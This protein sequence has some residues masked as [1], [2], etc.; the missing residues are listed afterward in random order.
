MPGEPYNGVFFAA[1]CPPDL[2]DFDHDGKLDAVF[3]SK[4]NAYILKGRGDGSFDPTPTI[5]PIPGGGGDT[6]AVAAADFD[7]DGNPDFAVLYRLGS[8]YTNGTVVFVYYGNGDSTFS[9]PLTYTIPFHAYSLITAS[10]LNRDGLA[11]LVLRGINV[12]YDNWS[13]SILHAKPG[14]A[15][16]SEVNYIAGIG[17]ND[18]ASLDVNQDGFPDLLIANN[19]ANSVTVL[20]NPGNVP[21]VSGILTASPEPSLIN[22]PFTLTATL[23]PPPPPS[24]STLSGTVSFF[25]MASPSAHLLLPPTLPPSRSIT[26]SAEESIRSWQPGP[27]TPTI[28]PSP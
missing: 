20:I 5:L 9:A 23:Y 6:A 7:G 11:D 4:S 17:L 1:N 12:P 21:T 19:L 14:R 26:S 2:A 3:G 10:D 22:Q 25:L 24:T 27:A 16:D 13:I 15:F 18:L 8:S 28:R